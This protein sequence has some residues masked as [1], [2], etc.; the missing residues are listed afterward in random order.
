L[1]GTKRSEA[2]AQAGLKPEQV[3]EVATFLSVLPS[4]HVRAKVEMHGD[5]DIVERDVAKCIVGV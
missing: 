4:I 3:E 5:E 2:L 1:E